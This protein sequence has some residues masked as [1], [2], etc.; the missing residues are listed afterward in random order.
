ME[1][2]W[3]LL[4]QSIKMLEVA[5]A[6]QQ[7]EWCV[8]WPG[9]LETLTVGRLDVPWDCNLAETQLYVSTRPA[10]C[11]KV[12]LNCGI[13][14]SLGWA[15]T[16]NECHWWTSDWRFWFLEDS[17]AGKQV[18]AEHSDGAGRF[19]ESLDQVPLPVTLRSLIFGDHFDQSL[20]FTEL[21]DALSI[22]TFGQNFNQSLEALLGQKFELQT[23]RSDGFA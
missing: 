7:A 9:T 10:M 14:T 15:S 2:I 23:A 19:N 21:P 1:K 22:L 5:K 20:E 16:F 12:C 18:T 4:C 17:R 11:L 13:C 6:G 8:V 3:E